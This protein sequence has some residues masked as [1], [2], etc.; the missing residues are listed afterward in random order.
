MTNKLISTLLL[1]Q[2]HPMMMNHLTSS[3]GSTEAKVELYGRPD[4]AQIKLSTQ[5][6]QL[7][8]NLSFQLQTS[9]NMFT[10]IHKWVGSQTNIH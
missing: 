10:H 9:F 1:A 7:A 8:F 4:Q 6:Y 5:G 2:A 3:I